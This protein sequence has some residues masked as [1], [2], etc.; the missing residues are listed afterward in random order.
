MR[1]L[2]GYMQTMEVD[3]EAARTL[4]SILADLFD[5]HVSQHALLADEQDRGADFIIDAGER[6]WFV[7]VKSSSSP[8]VVTAAAE[9]L[10]TQPRADGALPLLVVPFMSPAGAKAAEARRLNWVDLSG[11][12]HLRDEGL[13]VWVQGHP[14][15]FVTRG[16]P[17]SPFAPKSSRITRALLLDPPRWWRQKEL[18]EHTDL[19]PGRVSRVVRALESEELLVRDGHRL[20]PRDPD[21]LLD[22]WADDYRFD[23]HD[24]ITGH[25]SGNGIELARM[26][27]A[28]LMN[29]GIDHALTGLPAA[30]LLDRFVQFR[31]VSV[32][33]SGDPRI[34]A[35]AVG[36]R[37]NER[38]ANVQLIGPNDRGVFDGQRSVDGLPCVA[39]VQIY[40][41]LR[42]LPERAAEAAEELRAE[43]G[44]WRG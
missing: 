34:A 11:N 37:R 1:Q 10:T 13:V 24:I 15:R 26:L 17:A 35:D 3:R 23:R 30:W 39:P 6:R 22:A 5:Q 19:D 2:R 8:G 28:S 7:Q 4:P 31:V 21:L 33:V 27:G 14:N 32:Y 18:A 25:V 41:D 43:G 36:L 38:G 9:R 16:R 42:H 29:E 12:A 20:R 40:L 44:L